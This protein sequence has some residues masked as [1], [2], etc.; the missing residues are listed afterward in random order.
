MA[1]R[2]GMI[3]T[4]FR[5]TTWSVRGSGG[6]GVVWGADVRVTHVG[7]SDVQRADRPQPRVMPLRF[8]QFGVAALLADAPLVA[9]PGPGPP[10][11]RAPAGVLPRMWCAHA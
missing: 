6:R 2:G 3:K 10:G 11:V 5:H 8:Q 7:V 1:E 9:H 4:R